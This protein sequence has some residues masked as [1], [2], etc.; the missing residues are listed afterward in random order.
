[1]IGDN[2]CVITWSL[3]LDLSM[4]FT[5]LPLLYN[6]FCGVNRERHRWHEKYFRSCP[7]LWHTITFKYLSTFPLTIFLVEFKF[8][9]Q[10]IFTVHHH[11]AVLYSIFQLRTVP[12]KKLKSQFLRQVE[13]RLMLCGLFSSLYDF[14]F[15]AD[16]SCKL[17]AWRESLVVA[18]TV[19]RRRR[20]SSFV[21]VNI[22]KMSS[23]VS[24]DPSIFLISHLSNLPK[25]TRCP[26]TQS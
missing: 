26:A 24:D 11:T 17:R 23:F 2:F 12:K 20:R 25:N 7:K 13:L 15:V 4:S 16:E 8:R 1:M 6:F 21:C 5:D 19:R 3:L 10:F 22:H 18:L 9:S 14:F